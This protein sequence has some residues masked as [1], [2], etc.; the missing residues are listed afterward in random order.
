MCS[1]AK[2][3][4]QDSAPGQAGQVLVM[5]PP[6]KMRRR[7]LWIRRVWLVVFVLFCLE[8][9]IILTWCPWTKIWTQNSILM[10]FPTVRSFLMKNFVR[11]AI[12]GVG[13]VNLWMGVAEAVRYREETN[14]S[15][16]DQGPTGRP[17]D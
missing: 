17:T 13:L 11:G 3:P 2:L 12:S 5:P 4:G 16:D 8:I 10:S 1:F 6:Q 7:G 15:A 9:G 14:S